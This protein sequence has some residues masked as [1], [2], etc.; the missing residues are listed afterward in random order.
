MK[1]QNTSIDTHKLILHLLGLDLKIYRLRQGLYQLGF[2]GG[3][4]YTD[5][6]HFAYEL[7]NIPQER[8]EEADELCQELVHS[9]TC[10]NLAMRFTLIP[11]V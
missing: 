4:Y 11:P 5:L 3:A 10:Q 6:S 7:M 2:E 8:F 1:P 9:S